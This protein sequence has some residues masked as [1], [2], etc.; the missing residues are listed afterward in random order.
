[1]YA[2]P[3]GIEGLTLDREGDL[4]VPQRGGAAGC[5]IMRIDPEGGAGQ[6]GVTVARMSPPCNPAGLAFGPDRRLYVTG[7]GAVGDEIGVVTPNDAGSANPPMVTGFATG[8]PGANGVAFDGNGNLYASDGGTAQGRVFRVGRSGGAAVVLF[9][10]PP[11]AN[12][13]GVGRQNQALQPPA[14]GLPPATQ[15]IVANGLAF[16]RDDEL[17]IADTAR[18][19]LWRVELNRRGNVETPTGCDTTFTADTLCLDALF[20]Q[21]PALDGADGI[22]LDRAGNVWVDAN[23]RNA[24]VLVDRRGDVSE[25]FRNP[26]DAGNL[27]N[28][29]PLEFPTSPVLAGRRFCTTSSDGNRRDNAPNSAG[30]A[31]PGSSVLGKVSCLDQKL[32][33]PGERLPVD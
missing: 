11:M 1:M 3:I 4:Y 30:E 10:V 14:T 29:G 18:G 27:R 2:S 15:G 7:F 23:E 24:V 13:V 22:A 31:R 28:V 8:T 9:R 19:A 25:F 20:V 5:S 17:F 32:D 16:G 12:A 6:T 21:H 33:V 26:V